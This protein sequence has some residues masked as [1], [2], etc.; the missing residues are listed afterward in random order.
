MFLGNFHLI[1]TLYLMLQFKGRNYIINWPSNSW[2]LLVALQIIVRNNSQTLDMWSWNL[3]CTIKHKI[4][5]SVRAESQKEEIGFQQR[6]KMINSQFSKAGCG[7][8]CFTAALKPLDGANMPHLWT[9]SLMEHK[10]QQMT[11]PRC[12]SITCQWESCF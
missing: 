11:L 12:W 4:S 5:W 1:V 6:I 10:R 9:F 8:S 2:M 3:T 7:S